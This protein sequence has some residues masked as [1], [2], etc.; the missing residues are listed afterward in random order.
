LAPEACLVSSDVALFILLLLLYHHYYQR[1]LQ[2]K[3][4]LNS[5]V[6]STH[7]LKTSIMQLKKSIKMPR[8]WAAGRWIH[9]HWGEKD[10][11]LLLLMVRGWDTIC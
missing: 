6:M 1:P 8:Q 7:L 9:F 5:T 3:E 11:S 2:K 10:K 4:V